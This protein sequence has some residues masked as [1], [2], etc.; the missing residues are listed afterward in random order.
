MENHY[1]LGIE[2]KDSGA[3]E[4]AW[5]LGQN[6]N[7]KGYSTRYF[8]N[9]WGNVPRE[10]CL[11][12]GSASEL[13]LYKFKNL[14]GIFHLQTHVWEDSGYLEQIV[15]KKKSKIIYNLHA[16]IPY[17]YLGGEDKIKFLEGKLEPEKYEKIIKEKM[18]KREKTQLI[19]MEKADHLFVLAEGHKKVLE[20]MNIKKP[21]HIFENISDVESM[22]KESLYNSMLKGKEFRRKI[23]TDNAI[24]YCGRLYEKK[25][26]IGL[27]DSFDKINK[28]YGNAK[29]ILL[30]S[31]KNNI[32][33][34]LKC[35]LKEEN[36][37][38]IVFVPWIKKDTTLEK[39]EFLKYYYASDVLIQPMITEKL[40]AKTVIDAMSIGL[41]AITCKSPYTIGTS[42]NSD[43][44]FDSFVQFKENPKETKRI[45]EKAKKKVQEEN[46]WENYISRMREIVLR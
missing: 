36:I 15:N 21:I 39:E 30:G 29:L 2:R 17:Y 26:S 28:A 1:I 20:I 45:V 18:S 40:F 19:T 12:D 43:E 41:P 3:F 8:S 46:T 23:N 7:E 24:L 9:W 44:I 42:K 34:L 6:L 25:G 35:G 16:I 5:N 13:N 11:K 27:F 10:L 22:S 38:D 37:K 14:S 33:N 32:E 4:H 31:D